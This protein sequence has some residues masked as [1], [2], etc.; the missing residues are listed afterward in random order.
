MDAVKV[1]K[2]YVPTHNVAARLVVSIDKPKQMVTSEAS[3][4][5][6]TCGKHAGSKD[7]IPKE[8][9]V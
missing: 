1:T 5:R 4:I 6:K 9:D 8:N 3:K 2:S 7:I